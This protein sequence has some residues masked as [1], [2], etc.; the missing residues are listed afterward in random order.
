M[1]EK[2]PMKRVI[3]LAICMLFSSAILWGQQTIYVID[4]VT[5]D[6]FDGSQLKGKNI[7][8]YQITTT[9]KGT[10]A[11][12]VHAITTTPSIN[13][14]IGDFPKDFSLPKD[15]GKGVHVNA[16]SLTLSGSSIM[17]RNPSQKMLYII[18]GE[19]T[20]DASALQKL[21]SARIQKIQMYKGGTTKE[22]FGTDLPVM[23]IETKDVEND[24]NEV[25]KMLPNVKVEKDGTIT[26]D[27]KPIK[28]VTINGGATY[29]DK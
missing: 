19:R 20:E 13:A 6:N 11:I 15:L 21:S 3:T 5:V 18:D 14:F 27:G 1:I 17:L 8:D 26:V 29:E 24:L 23:V 2:N 4:N 7:K 16:D 12:T 25:L 28:K 10:K 9:G 22:K